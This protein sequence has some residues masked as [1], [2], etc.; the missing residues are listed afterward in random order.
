MNSKDSAEK[1]VK[2]KKRRNPFRY[3]LY[4]FIKITG[5]IGAYLWLRPKRIFVSKKAK[6]HIKGGAI[7][8]ANHTNVRDPIAMYF[9]FWYRRVHIMAMKEIFST[10]LGNWF[11]SGAGCIPVDR[12]NLNMQTF[13][14]SIEV[15]ED[16]KILGV[17]PEGQINWEKGT[18]SPFKSGAALMA[19]KARVPIVPLYISHFTKWYKR[20]VIVI[21]EPIDPK[22]LCEG[23]PSLHSLEELSNQLR[24]KEMQLME[25]YEKWKKK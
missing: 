17:F 14:S 24:E 12:H 7:A 6:K 22:E 15:L 20:T 11:F 3:F 9:A 21:G 4:D 13:R 16:G 1:K 19:F 2:N 25:V 8:I 23:T 18:V 5:A 10:K